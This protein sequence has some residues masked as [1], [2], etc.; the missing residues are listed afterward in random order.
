MRRSISAG[1]LLSLL[2]CVAIT[3]HA[4]PGDTL[5]YDNL[6][7]NLNSWTVNESGGDANIDDNA[8]QQGRSLELRW[9]VV[10]IHT[11]PISAAVPGAELSL[12]I[13]RGDN[14]FSN[15]PEAGED[16]VLEYRDSGG[17]WVEIDTYVGGGTAGQTYTPTYELDV[18][19]LHS[20]LSIRLRMTGGNG[21][22]YDYWHI[23]NV[24]VTEIA[25]PATPPFSSGTC[26][27]FESGLAGWVVNAAGGSAGVSTQ[28]AN[29][30]SNSLYTR[31]GVVSVTSIATDLT[32]SGSL[33]LEVWVRRGDDSFSENPEDGEDLVLEYFTNGGAWSEL[34][35]FPGSGSAGEILARNYSLPA[36]AQ[37]ASFS[38]RLRQT[39]GDGSTYDYW[40]IDD[41][42]LTMAPILFSFEEESW[43]GAGGEIEDSGSSGLSGTAFGGATNDNSAPALA[44]N[45]GTCR[46]GEFDGVNDYIEVPDNPALDLSSALTVAAWI[47]M[48]TLPVGGGLHTIASKDTN[49]EFHIDSSGRVYWWWNDSGGATRSITTGASITLNQWHHIAIVYESGSQTIYVDGNVWA[50]AGFGGNLAQNDLPFFIGTDYNLI[51]RAFDGYIDEVVVE[52]S[53]Y[54]QAQV[55]TLRDATHDCATVS[56]GFTLNH[57][58]FGI[59][60][61]AETV[62]VDVID[63]VSGTPLTS[64]NADVQLDT[65]TGNGSWSLVSGAGTLTDATADDGIAVYAWPLNE[66]QAQFALSYTQGTPVFDIDAFQVSDSG[67]RDTD[68]EGDIIFSASGFTLTASALGNPP[69]GAISGFS[70]AQ[71]AAVPFTVHI[72]AYGQTPDDA[73]CGVIESYTGNQNLKFWSDYVNPGSGFRSVEVDAN[74]VAAS[75]GAAASQTVSFV[76]G[77]AAVSVKYKDAGS[78]R[79]SVRDDTTTNAELPQGITGA[80]AAFVS[81]PADFVLSSIANAAG[82]ISNP[83]PVAVDHNGSR[84]IAAGE[85]FRATVTALDAEGDA[86]PNYGREV[87][88]ETVRLESLLVAPNPGNNPAV[89]AGTGFAAFAAGSAT[90]TDFTWSEVG[91]IQLRPG[92][93]D[94][95]YLGAGDV[96]GTVSDNVGRFVPADFVLARNTPLLDTQCDA[97]GFTYTGESFGY[98]VAPTIT[99]TAVAVG[100]SSTQNYSGDFFKLDTPTL[101]NLIYSTAAGTLDTSGLPAPLVADPAVVETANGVA[102]ISFSAGTGFN[103]SRASIHSPF[104]AAIELAIDIVD[105]DGIASSANPAEFGAGSGMDF[106]AGR[107]IRYGRL[108]FTNA[109]GSE[110]VDL[111]VP[112]GTEYYDGPALGFRPNTADSCTTG[113]TVTLGPF[114]ENLSGGETCVLDNGMPGASGA[115]CAVAAPPSRQFNATAVA[116]DFNLSLAAPGSSNHGSVGI[117]ADAPSW[118]EYDW[119]SSAAGNEDPSGTA[120]F[121][122]YG[123]ESSQLYIQEIY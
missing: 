36:D 15:Y 118:L 120:V 35:T 103:F 24:T 63:A 81:R 77:Q 20:N 9:G 32:G 33:E 14:G 117:S 72:A 18:A 115:G 25:G 94:G 101:Q 99:A 45:P 86:T 78:I 55:Q 54:S 114:T 21:S 84:F 74:P 92:I 105:G 116:G 11:D 109:I 4:A 50:S 73:A 12:W 91:I 16:L 2:S 64:Y 97:G 87:I 83:F 47:N 39:D 88:A 67:I 79:L 122:I 107:S 61:V 42:C 19:A 66:T 48:Q 110:L 1:Y 34:E 51:E 111:L 58:G 6:N 41:I 96:V 5:F 70:Q 60:C 30:P 44:T 65:Q 52:P 75:S 53:A 98:T 62:T 31:G 113:V 59:H 46:Y 121:G 95:N 106:S 82:T 76:N 37:H 8:A 104:D 100:G 26:E 7:G 112:L 40:H 123:G 28:T 68:A 22:D 108:G 57:D 27:N 29:S 71:T 3:A 49:Y 89:S 119:D 93:G 102:T 90:G 17:S 23:D 80:T 69:P 13:R 56:A 10:S 85:P 43:T 38:V